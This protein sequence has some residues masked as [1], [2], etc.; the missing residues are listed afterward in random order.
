MVPQ[1]EP[2][3]RARVF[4]LPDP[5]P[6][7]QELCDLPLAV[8]QL[9][10]VMRDVQMLAAKFRFDTHTHTHT[11][12]HRQGTH[13]PPPLPPHAH[14]QTHTHTHTHTH[15][16]YAQRHAADRSVLKPGSDAS[17]SSL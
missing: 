9:D 3:I 14:T 2:Y 11:R 7:R 8:D 6:S 10:D 13:A 1:V 4:S 12:A 17:R 5:L 16:A 15:T